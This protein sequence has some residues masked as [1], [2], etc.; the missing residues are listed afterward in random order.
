MR[1]VKTN[2]LLQLVT[3][4][5]DDKRVDVKQMVKALEKGGFEVEGSPKYLK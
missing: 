2:V 5:F 1:D 3:V 4:T